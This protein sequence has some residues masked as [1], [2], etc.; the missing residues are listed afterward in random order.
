MKG[1]KQGNCG[2]PIVRGRPKKMLL[3]TEKKGGQ[4]PL[5]S[6]VERCQRGVCI[7]VSGWV[8]MKGRGKMGSF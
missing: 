1:G 2:D 4:V 8:K 7:S 3:F 6:E 5:V